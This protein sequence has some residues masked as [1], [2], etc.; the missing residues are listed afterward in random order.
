MRIS[1]GRNR[2]SKMGITIPYIHWHENYFKDM[3]QQVLE[4]GLSWKKCKGLFCDSSWIFN[5]QNFNVA[6]DGKPYAAF[7]HLKEPKLVGNIFDITNKISAQDYRTQFTFATR[8]TRRKK[9]VED[10]LFEV[11]VFGSFYPINKMVKNKKYFKYI[12]T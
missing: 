7:T 12:K 1:S 2:L 8:N 3:N 11:K 10:G 4:I 9:Y 5:P 6:P